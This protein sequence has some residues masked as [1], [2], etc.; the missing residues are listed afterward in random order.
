MKAKRRTSAAA[1]RDREAVLV[2]GR[3][4]RLVLDGR[5]VQ[6][7][8]ADGAGVGAD[9]PAPPVNS[10]WEEVDGKDSESPVEPRRRCL[11][12]ARISLRALERRALREE[13]VLS[14][15]VQH[16][17]PRN[18]DSCAATHRTSTTS[19]LQVTVRFHSTTLAGADPPFCAARLLHEVLN[20]A[21][22]CH[23]MC[24]K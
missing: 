5:L 12:E 24:E 22:T 21:K 14:D 8:T 4:V 6:R 7:V 13:R 2:V 16:G 23:D 1:E 19:V 20:I 9:I 17:P 3:R 15:A 11:R 10:P 18:G